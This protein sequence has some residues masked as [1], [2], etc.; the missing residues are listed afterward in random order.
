MEYDV[1]HDESQEGGYWHA[2]LLVPRTTRQCFL[3]QLK[4][5]RQNTSYSQVVCLKGLDRTT[6]PRF[7]C[8][9]A[10]LHFGVTALMQNLKGKPYPFYT[11]IDGR[12]TG[13]AH[14]R[15]TIG[16][17]FILFRVRDGHQQLTGYPDHAAKVETTFRMGLK[18]G[19]HLF[20]LNSSKLNVA[21]FHFDG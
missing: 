6:G 13:F 16:A 14:L 7:R 11:G 21:S 1:Y 2:I 5:I 20:S 15:S 9:R 12:N 18:G 10:W 17:R 4:E 8:I 3:A 19:L